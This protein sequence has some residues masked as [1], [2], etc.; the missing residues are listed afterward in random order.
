M[1]V[2]LLSPNTGNL[3]V[4]KGKVSFKKTGGAYRFMGNCPSLEI[5]PTLEKLEHFS[6]MEGTKTKDLTII[7]S[8]SGTVKL[9]L[10]EWTPDNLAL[11]LMGEIDEAAVGGPEIDIFS[12]SE[13][14]GELKFE[15]ANDVGPQWDITLYNVSFIPSAA[16]N[17]ISDE[18]GQIEITGDIL[19]RANDSKFGLAKLTNMDAVS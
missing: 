7:L 6:S 16:F 1:S 13:I 18:F 12:E 9:I 3:R 4:G 2:T 10:E 5:T 15:S 19:I 14:T 11:I 8:K 17:P